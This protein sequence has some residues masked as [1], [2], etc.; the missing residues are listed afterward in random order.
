MSGPRKEGEPERFEIPVTPPEIVSILGF[1]ELENR[2]RQVPLYNESIKDLH[3]Y[4]RSEISLEKVRIDNLHPSAFYVVKEKLKIQ[5]ALRESLFSQGV[6]THRLGEDTTII[7]YSWGDREYTLVPPIIEISED[8]GF[9]HVITDGLHRT[10]NARDC[11]EG[12]MVAVIIRNTA[13]P[14]SV[15]PVSWHEVKRV[16]KIPPLS[17]KRRLR[18]RKPEEVFAWFGLT[19]RNLERVVGGLSVPEDFSYKAFFRN[20]DFSEKEK[21]EQVRVS[22]SSSLILTTLE[23][24]LLN[25]RILLVQQA[26]D[27]EWGIVAGKLNFDP[28]SNLVETASEIIIRELSE[29][30]DVQEE[31]LE[32]FSFEGNLYIPRQDKLS[33]GFIY[34]AYIKQSL[35][36]FKNGYIPQNSSEIRQVKSFSIDDVVELVNSPRHIYRPEFNIPLMRFWAFEAIYWKYEP[37]EGSEFAESIAESRTGFDRSCRD[38]F[39]NLI[40]RL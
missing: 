38:I 12:E 13:V 3:P 14:L 4:S 37:W 1:S 29:E 18:F 35:D 28:Q 32:Y 22:V 24:S 27:G 17:E 34:S 40:I 5:K 25:R 33:L 23:T 21:R 16:D 39:R 19:N 6:D 36:R 11:N 10:T 31:E 30:T 26:V 15:L 8:D 9:M 2:I 7:R 20:L